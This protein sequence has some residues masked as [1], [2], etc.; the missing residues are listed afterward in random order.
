M[1][2]IIVAHYMP[3]FIYILRVEER[4]EHLLDKYFFE[5]FNMM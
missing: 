1:L 3:P 4:L 5:M 2:L